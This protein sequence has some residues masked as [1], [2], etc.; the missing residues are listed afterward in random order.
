[1]NFILSFLHFIGMVL[2][3]ILRSKSD[4]LVF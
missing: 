4:L 2:D 3:N 1:L